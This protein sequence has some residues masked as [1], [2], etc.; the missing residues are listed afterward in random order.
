LI[1]FTSEFGARA[2]KRL[3][4]E[5]IAWLTTTSL[6][7]TP[8]PNPIW[9]FWDGK[10]FLIYSQPTAHKLKNIRRNPKVSL[11]LQVDAEG[12]RVLVLAG[13]ASIDE[14]PKH[15]SR[16]IAKYREEIP[17]IGETTESLA[18][19]YSVL[20]RVSPSNMRGF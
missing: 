2:A 4:E 3:Q 9:F 12:G 11:N 17:K 8:Q 15:D 14:N 18:A 10:E 13:T 5:R 19:S 6:D 7:G 1:D 16:Y 20:I